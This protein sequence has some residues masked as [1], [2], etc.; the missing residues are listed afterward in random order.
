MKRRENIPE[1]DL[2]EVQKK[3]SKQPYFASKRGSM[4]SMLLMVVIVIAVAGFNFSSGDSGSIVYEAN[5]E[6]FGIR[7]LNEPPVFINYQDIT[8]LE[9]VA[10]FEMGGVMMHSDW[11]KGWC[12][13]YENANWGEYTLYAYSDVG[14]YIVLKYGD[15]V[16]VFNGK[17]L[18]ETEQIYGELKKKL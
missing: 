11:D 12:G 3:Q 2:L 13:Q 7:C 18:K 4:M 17:N 1:N 10:V 14:K 9:D 16:L 8:A 6:M 15:K 5:D